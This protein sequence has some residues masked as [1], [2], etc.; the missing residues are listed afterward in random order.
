MVLEATVIIIDNSEWSRNGD[1]PPTRYQSQLDS[2]HYLFQS[3]TNDNPENTVGVIANSGPT[4][5]V[6]VSLTNDSGDLLRGLHG[7]KIHGTAQFDIGIQVAQLVLKHR[8]NKNQKQRIVVFAASPVGTEDK[9]LVKLG[10]KLK[11]NGVSVD[12][13]NFGEHSVNE[14]KLQAFVEAANNN[15]TS[16]L[17]TIPPGP[18]LLSEQIK[19]SAIV[20]GGA[21]GGGEFGFGGDGDMDPELAMA[22]R[23]SLQE[24]E[25][26]Q[27]RTEPQQ[28][29]TSEDAVMEDM[30][31]DEQI[32][33]AIQMSLMEGGEEEK[34]G[35]NNDVV[36]SLI[37]SLPG[38]DPNDPAL[39]NALGGGND[40]DKDEDKNKDKKSE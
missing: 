3:K 13:V 33:R 19:T 24:E 2:I 5:Q 34:E 31:E 10:K 37:G 38:V 22:L 15:D 11:K 9:N 26:R 7:L 27:R 6:L 4:P 14:Q 12:V 35:E 20:G 30:D 8:A 36:A 25:E 1:Y 28:Q 23:M 40:D 18:Q 32:R 29:E 17:V 21:E 16:H 39:Q